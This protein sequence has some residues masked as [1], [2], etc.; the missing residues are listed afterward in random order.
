MKKIGLF[1]IFIAAIIVIAAISA[2]LRD[3]IPTGVVFGFGLFAFT[4]I[5]CR[6]VLGWCSGIRKFLAILLLLI[7]VIQ[8][9][10]IYQSV[11]YAS[12][13]ETNIVYILLIVVT[14]FLMLLDL[15]GLFM[16]RAWYFRCPKCKKMFYLV[17]SSTDSETRYEMRRAEVGDT[18]SEYTGKVVQRHYADVKH[19]YDKHTTNY[20]CKCC[21]FTKKKIRN[22]RSR[23]VG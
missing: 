10:V 6:L 12:N 15:F 8:S 13:L 18:R 21:N 20:V 17:K 5:L 22:G 19:S 2:I 3:G 9:V 4:L 11:V 16:L 23:R 7:F 14:G 1:D